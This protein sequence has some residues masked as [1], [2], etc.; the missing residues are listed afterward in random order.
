MTDLPLKPYTLRMKMEE[1]YR[2]KAF[3]GLKIAVTGIETG[4]STTLHPVLH[5]R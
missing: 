1:R 3:T 5:R 4:A 2:L